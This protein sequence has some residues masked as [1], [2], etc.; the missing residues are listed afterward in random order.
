M[1]QEVHHN[2]VLLASVINLNQCLRD[3]DRFKNQP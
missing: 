2:F 3:Q 1:R